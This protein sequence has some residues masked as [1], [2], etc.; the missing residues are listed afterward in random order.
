M[1]LKSAAVNPTTDLKI[2]I[3]TL[4]SK[5]GNHSWMLGAILAGMS[6]LV[7]KAFF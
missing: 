2:E 3:K 6:S 7:L 4:E 1:G 5:V